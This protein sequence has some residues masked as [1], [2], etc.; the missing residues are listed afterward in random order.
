MGDSKDTHGFDNPRPIK[1]RQLKL[2]DLEN[3]PIWSFLFQDEELAIA[4]IRRGE[5]LY[6]HNL[7]LADHG[8]EA[9]GQCYVRRRLVCQGDADSDAPGLSFAVPA[10]ASSLDYVFSQAHNI[11]L[12]AMTLASRVAWCQLLRE[13]QLP[14]SCTINTYHQC[15]MPDVINTPAVDTHRVHFLN[16]CVCE[17]APIIGSGCR[18]L[19]LSMLIGHRDE[20]VQFEPATAQMYKTG[21]WAQAFIRD[22]FEEIV[23]EH[24]EPSQFFY[25]CGYYGAQMLSATEAR[26]G[27]QK[28][29]LIE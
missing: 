3:Y 4:V 11:Y 20:I 9:A 1:Q 22:E 29:T 13:V 2:E 19:V 24:F 10:D 8:I 14:R 21:L 5:R 6:L 17:F 23:F 18:R 28:L 7:F 25:L 15:I 26:R 12:S 27:T 16:P